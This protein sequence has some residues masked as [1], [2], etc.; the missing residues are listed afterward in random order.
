MIRGPFT[1]DDLHA[2]ADGRLTADRRQELER[3]LAVDPQ[4]AE[5]AAFYRDLND[6]LHR[7]YDPLLAEPLPRELMAVV[8]AKRQRRHLI[9]QLARVAAV[10]VVLFVGGVG[11][12][13]A[14]G[15]LPDRVESAQPDLPRLA[16]GAHLVFAAEVRHPVEVGAD[17]EAH[18]LAWL[19]KRLGSEV[20]APTLTAYGYNLM[21][22][23]LLPAG[24][25]VAGQFMY[26][27][28]AGTRLSLFLAAGGSS[29][30]TAF[31]FVEEDGVSVFYWRDE[32]LGYALSAELPREQLLAI[33]NEIYTQLY[34]EAG[35]VSW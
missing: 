28:D 5:R 27:N 16:A 31:R 18:L 33:C 15:L 35:P 2:H 20:K 12:W 19:S 30:D 4:A 1:D 23:R 25:G 8:E 10:A 26:E 9:G 17:Q 11:G 29:N 22:G 3:H 7:L 6:A 24:D 14:R 21:G 32:G 34:P 13:L